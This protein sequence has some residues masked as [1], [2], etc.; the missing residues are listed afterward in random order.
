MKAIFVRILT[1]FFLYDTYRKEYW[2][3]RNRHEK[4]AAMARYSAATRIRF[5]LN[6]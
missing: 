6:K 3:A 4:V 2:K 1:E 5:A